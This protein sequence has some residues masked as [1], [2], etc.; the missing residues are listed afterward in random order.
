MP[1]DVFISHS[2]QDKLIAEAVCNRLESAAV[3]CWIAPRDINPGEGW[4]AAILRGIEACRVLILVFSDHANESAHI[5]REVAHACSHELIVIP[6]R[7][8]DTMPRGDLQYYLGELHWLDALTPPLEKHLEVLTARV[9]HLLS[10]YPVSSNET[11][12]QKNKP[13]PHHR[14]LSPSRRVIILT[15]VILVGIVGIGVTMFL[16]SVNK[17]R[18]NVSPVAETGIPIP[19]VVNLSNG[20]RLVLGE[21]QTLLNDKELGLHDMAGLGLAVTESKPGRLQFL[22]EV[23]ASTYSVE[24][25]DIRHLASA[26]KV[27]TPG[28]AG[29]FDNC[30]AGV[31]EIVRLGDKI[32]AFYEARDC[33]SMPVFL[34]GATHGVYCSIGLAESSDG[35]RTWLKRGQIVKSALSKEEENNPEK[36]VRGVGQPGAVLDTSG[37]YIYLYYACFSGCVTGTA[38]ISIA[39]SDLSKG[40]PLPG[41]W[42]KLYGGNFSEP[43]LGGKETVVFDSYASEK[44]TCMYPHVLF[45]QRLKKY[46]LTFNASRSEEISEGLPP[47]ES[48]IYTALSDDGVKWSKPTKLVNTYSRRMVG[49]SIAIEPTIVLDSPEALAGWLVYSYTPKLTNGTVSGT[50]LYLAGRRIE[51][52]KAE[53]N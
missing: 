40:P 32:Y 11:P 10:S 2:G 26:R 17:K 16:L 46:I 9:T 21:Q 6:M 24:G 25:T 19:P 44:V 36:G 52:V 18:E 47:T 15:S 23:G 33:E 53:S 34:A 7:I 35:G 3:R 27:L 50:E 8:R 28:A 42:E 14:V 41:T 49:V 43:G 12:P 45:S 13:V 51:F 38:Q 1:Y 5:R 20:L 39:R 37:R 22:F 31:G 48:G 30:A 29:E 4:S